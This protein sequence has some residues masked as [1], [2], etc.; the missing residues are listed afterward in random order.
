MSEMLCLVSQSTDPYFNL[1][2]EEYFLKYTNEELF[3]LYVNQPSIV[4][5]KHQNLLSEINLSWAREN[6]VHLARRITGG[7]TVYHD[8]GN[9]NFSFVTVC[10][11][12]ENISYKRFTL[13]IVLTINALGI[14]AKYSGRNDLLVGDRKISGNAMHIYKNRVLTHGTLLYKSD[15]HDLSSA[16][17][18]HPERY[19]DK[20][21]KSITS[22]VVN[23]S[24]YFVPPLSM[25]EFVQSVFDE[26]CKHLDSPIYYTLSSS[27]IDKIERLSQEKFTAWDWIYGYSPK[28]VFKNE[29]VLSG[30]SVNF[31]L[32]VEKGLIKNYSLN[33]DK[34]P[35]KQIMMI[36]DSLI[37]AKH[38]Y[39]TLLNLFYSYNPTNLISGLS[40]KD[41]CDQFF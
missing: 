20:S 5:G 41:F 13:P 31:Q 15:L 38:D 36:F 8:P 22:P 28:Y 24:E 37:N 23:I 40:V 34:K 14:D 11:N 4:V 6:K 27:D 10:P 25:E 2:A 26:T 16:L 39:Q 32:S 7:G 17:R 18:N 33:G 12:L 35:V 19:I 1:A 9:L 29:I 3:M 21:I 30:Q